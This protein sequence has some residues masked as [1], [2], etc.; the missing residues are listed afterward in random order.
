MNGQIL[1][2][3]NGAETARRM[4][5]RLQSAGYSVYLADHLSEALLL[6]EQ[7]EFDL[8]MVD[9]H[10]SGMQ[11]FDFV[12][13]MQKGRHRM[14]IIVI[15]H[16]GSNEAAAALEAG[17]ND[18]I[19]GHVDDRELLARVSNLLNLFHISTQKRNEKI[20]IGD[21]QIDPLSRQVSRGGTEIDLTQREYDLLI[22]LT[23]RVNEVCTRE[24]ILSHVWDCDFNTGT[25]VVDVYILHL[26][27]KLDKGRKWKLIRTIRGAG[28]MLAAPDNEHDSELSSLE[29][30]P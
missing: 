6:L 18:Y 10:L 27:E 8:L 28:Y 30:A 9:S 4:M 11:E 29:D 7:V 17:A 2:A 25:N 23:E 20:K 1:L 26:R 16:S 15:G 14:P 21:L 22:Y 3:M 19:S 5:G 24:E 12:H 13:R